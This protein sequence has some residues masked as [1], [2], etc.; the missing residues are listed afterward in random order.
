MIL[1]MSS[2]LLARQGVVKTKDGQTLE[3]DV[4]E[5]AAADT[6]SVTIHGAQVLLPRSDIASIDYGGDWQE[7]NKRFDALAPTDVRGRLD[8]AQWA[9]QRNMYEAARRA[10]EDARRIEPDNAE[11]A[12]LLKTIQSQQVM[13]SR[14]AAT[15][16]RT[17]PVIP[18]SAPPPA[19]SPPRYLSNEDVNL[20]RQ[21]ELRTDD[22]V[23]IKFVGDVRQRYLTAV[24]Q[25]RGAFLAAAPVD[26]AIQ[27]IQTGDARLTRD[28]R[29]GGD[30]RPL[31]QF[32]ARIQ[33]RV[34]V[35]CAAGGCHGGNSGAGGLFLYSDTPDTAAWYT[36]FY[37][38]Q[39]YKTQINAPPSVWGQGPAERSMLDRIHPTQ[40]LLVQF[41]LP[42]SLAATPHPRVAGWQPI[43]SSQNDPAYLD[44][45]QWIGSLKPVEPDY[46]IQFELPKPSA[47]TRR[48]SG[49]APH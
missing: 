5:T 48:A 27:I 28:V 33:K 31:G 41:G 20:I 7:F 22:I 14:Q 8:L 1:A 13:Q 18:P 42:A 3:G 32:Q 34:V 36:N 26:Q 30:P 25:D 40:S 46:Q 11:A 47:S 21:T 24:D 23:P 10:T 12:L 38:L 2:A 17:I 15:T 39:M 43:F 37:I 29:I 6:V 19:A 44:M 9:L 45:V 49:A 35:G 4:N 16:R